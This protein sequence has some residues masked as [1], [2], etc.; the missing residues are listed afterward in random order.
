MKKFYE[1]IINFI[2]DYFISK[3]HTFFEKFFYFFQKDSLFFFSNESDFTNYL[4]I[5]YYE[6]FVFNKKIILL[7]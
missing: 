6:S 3:D 2:S 4:L 1:S 5:N 7:G